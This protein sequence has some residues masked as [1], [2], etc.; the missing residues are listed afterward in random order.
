[1]TSTQVNIPPIQM[2]KNFFEH[3]QIISNPNFVP[4]NEPILFETSLWSSVYGNSNDKTRF[5][6]KMLIKLPNPPHPGVP[7]IASFMAVGAFI[8]KEDFGPGE[9]EKALLVKTTGG[10]IL[11]GAAREF[12]LQMT[13]RCN[14]DYI[15]L[16]LPTFSL[17][18]IA[19]A[20][21]IETIINPTTNLDKG[22]TEPIAPPA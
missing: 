6:L 22:A 9:A 11:Y 19:M 13:S 16:Y 2:E 5:L 12:I 8:V 14:W 20:P 1:M 7:M 21:L 3:A 17:Q 10:G 15:P 18:A 4:S